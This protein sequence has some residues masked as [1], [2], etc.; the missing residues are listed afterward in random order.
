ME[1]A[2]QNHRIRPLARLLGLVEAPR[3]ELAFA[4]AAAVFYRLQIGNS[5]LTDMPTNAIKREMS[6]HSNSLLREHIC[7][8][9]NIPCKM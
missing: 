9:F 1:V 8:F 3:S 6:L 2:Y 7:C 5:S 4:S